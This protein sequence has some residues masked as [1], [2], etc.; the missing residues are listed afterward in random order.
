MN[1]AIVIPTIDPNQ[2][3]LELANDL[4]ARNLGRIVVVDDGSDESCAPV[5]DE[6]ER[7]GAC[8]VHHATNLGKGAAIKT[9]IMA[10][11]A[12]FPQTTH[13]VTADADGQHPPDD[14]ERVI[15]AAEGHHDHVVIGTRDL[16]SREVPLRSRMGNAF[17]SAYFKFDT[18]MTCPDTQT[19]LRAIP[20]SLFSLALSTPG[21][22]YEYEMNF[23][24]TV[25]KRD[26]PLVML[27]IQTVYE[28]N[29]ASSHF[30]TIRDSARI[31]KQLIRFAGSS[32][33]CSLVD[34]GL[35]ALI[36]VVVNLNTAL[37]VAAATIIARM[38]SGL[39]NFSLNRSWSFKDAG[40]PNGDAMKQMKRYCLLFFA[41]MAAS[42]AFVWLLSSLPL[43]LVGVKMLVDSALFV[44]SY[45]V[46]RNWVFKDAP[47]NRAIIMK[48]GA[49]HVSKQSEKFFPAA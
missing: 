26:I 14:I 3:L 9:G 6:L 41:Q 13:I 4:Q 39:L 34:L 45:F 5:F 20:A 37:L 17:S 46:Q 15:R 10:V 36:S 1:A 27:P 18:G 11:R 43:P 2:K 22:R 7:A 25:A 38:C 16:G 31:Y 8:V 49:Q 40:S 30:S 33:T 42:S 48:G 28:D 24:T 29:N 47:K 23:L 32:L 21:T 12:R 35:F 19:G 44:V